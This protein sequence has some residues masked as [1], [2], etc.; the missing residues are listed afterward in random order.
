[1]T[2]RARAWGV[3]D[4][5]YDVFGNWHQVDGETLDRLVDRLSADRSAPSD[6][7]A[8]VHGELRAFQGDAGP[9]WGI[10]IQLYSVRSARN[11]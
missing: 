3:E 9:G 10:A 7:S 11:C 6:L 5:Y 8:P 1:M 4:G 2:D